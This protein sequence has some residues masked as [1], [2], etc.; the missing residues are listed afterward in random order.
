V[1]LL[2]A[3]LI[4]LLSTGPG[5]AHGLKTEGLAGTGGDFTL[6]SASGPLSLK[7]LRGKVVLIFF[8]YTSCPDVCPISLSIIDRMFRRMDPDELNRVRALFITLDPERD[9]TEVLQRYTGYFHHNI[10]GLR[11]RLDVL[12]KVASQYGVQFQRKEL[13]NSALG[14][15]IAHTL[16]ILV[17]D[18]AGQL[19]DSLPHNIKSD[20][21]L[22]QVRDLLEM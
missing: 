9:T 6:T 13:P 15:S 22:S 17:V 12:T 4:H 3:L 11:D 7:D 18:R 19:K 1:S 10:I 8:G 21:L 16:S 5:V 14:Y 2:A 20:R